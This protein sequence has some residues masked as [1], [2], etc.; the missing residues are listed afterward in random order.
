MR[1][2][3]YKTTAIITI[4]SAAERTLGFLYRIVLSRY[5]GAEGLGLYQVAL[6][7]F[8]VFLTIGTGGIPITISRLKT[9]GYAEGKNEAG[10]S[11]LS[12]GVCFSLI[13]TLPVCVFFFIFGRHTGFLFSDERCI[14]LFTLLLIGLP[15]TCVYADIRGSFWGE[16]KFLQ[17]A[18]TE[19]FEE[20]V[21]VIAGVLLL[22]RFSPEYYGAADQVARGTRLACFAVVI[23]YLASFATSVILFFADGGKIRSPKKQ[24]RP[25][26]SSAMPITA[27]RT[28][29]TLIGSA[30]AVILPAM[31]IRAGLS[32]SEA[33]R[34][35]GVAAGMAMPVLSV[36]STFIGAI[37]LVLTPEFS[38]SFYK[39]R[40]QKLTADIERGVYSAFAFSC[41]FMPFF[42]VYGLSLGELLYSDRGAGEMIAKCAFMLLPMSVSLISTGILNS[43]NYEK[44]TLRFY[45]IGAALMLLCVFFLPSEIGAYAYPVGMTVSFVCTACLNM[46][47][48][49][50][51]YPLSGTLLKKC[52]L[53]FALTAPVAACGKA[54]YSL[55][56]GFLSAVPAMLLSGVCTLAANLLL[57]I[58]FRLFPVKKVKKTLF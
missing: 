46:L 38:E 15:F 57:W 58:A 45:F 36:P 10:D 18:L 41:L 4:L 35:F 52:L 14:G 8:A 9:K 48:L 24:F 54:L 42:F 17:P 3:V 7:L 53:A 25:L 21:M 33:L 13:L 12:A 5:I 51:R 50:A 16:K 34:T 40:T 29:S 30:V 22:N 47:F 28:C 43:M 1:N 20:A 2:N 19:L 39:K 31:L 11:A 55:F 6:S 27:V 26:F 32:P 37:S 44:Q 56:S 23:S 49:I